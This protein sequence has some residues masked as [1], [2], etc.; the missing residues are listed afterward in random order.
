MAQT[1]HRIKSIAD[2]DVV[3]DTDTHTSE[4]V[5][6]LLPYIDDT[7]F[8]GAKRFIENASHPRE[9]IYTRG[10]PLP[11][12][13]TPHSRDN[14]PETRMATMEEFNIDHTILN[15]G[16][17]LKLPTVQNSRCA[18]ALASGYNEWVMD[19]FGDTDS[20]HPTI[21][22]AAQKPALTV[23]EIDKWGDE[24][25]VAGV[26]IP[27]TGLNP[28]PGHEWFHP[29]YEAASEHD[30]PIV[31][32]GAAGA[33]D[34]AFPLQHEWTETFAESSTIAHPFSQMWNLTSIMFEGIPEFFPDLDFVFLESGIGWVPYLKWRLDDHYL[35]LPDQVPALE[36]LPSEYIADQFYFASQPFGLNVKNPRQ[37]G[38]M[39]EMAGTDS[40]MYASDIPHG[41][42]DPPE[43]VLNPIASHLDTED[44]ENV[45]GKTAVDLYNLN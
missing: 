22:V 3:V 33:M 25:N 43:E 6:D 12:W 11:T 8:K 34:R 26:H 39:V 40:V 20:I 44:V 42:F 13:A 30:L 41:D 37:M 23:E 19:T 31:F 16:F 1:N 4:S 38:Q 36:K 27:A 17:A 32:H 45:M 5:D 28:P 2:L 15:P 10:H 35:E 24:D 18:L 7:K 21:L 9:D 29:I 14:D